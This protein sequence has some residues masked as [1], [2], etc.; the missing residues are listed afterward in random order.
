MIEI[1]SFVGVASF[2]RMS[3]IFTVVCSHGACLSI[4]DTPHLLTQMREIQILPFPETER[5]LWLHHPSCV[6]Q[7]SSQ[8]G[9]EL[10][11]RDLHGKCMLWG[12]RL[13]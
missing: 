4:S 7:P 3:P 2:G 13:P 9:L 1:D 6:P 8:Q 5:S 11:W 10:G 12:A